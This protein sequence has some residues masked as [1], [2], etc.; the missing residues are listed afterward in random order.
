M[1]YKHL[2]FDLDHTLWDFE[3]N[4]REAL[5]D[6]Y[7]KHELNKKGILSSDLFISKYFEINTQMWDLFHKNLMDR[8]TL[9]TI[10]FEKT[11]SHFNVQDETLKDIFPEEYLEVLPTKK[12]LFPDVHEVLTY[13]SKKYTLH[14]ITNGFEKI[15]ALKINASGL[16]KYF[17]RIIISEQTGYKKPDK[18]IFQY[19]MKVTNAEI[20]ECIMIGDDL[21]ADIKGAINSGMD[22][23][24]FN[25][26]KNPCS[27]KITFEINSL[28]ELKNIF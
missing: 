17:D 24:F 16:G 13:L 23:V 7:E 18:E 26:N 6:L 10:R 2:F 15:Q 11:F 27:E 4:S 3:K 20:K 9:R 5:M 21:E 25:P 22:V 14:L 12:K 8:E 19:A 1:K 28:I